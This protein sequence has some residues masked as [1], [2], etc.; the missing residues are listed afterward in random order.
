MRNDIIEY[1][2]AEVELRCRSERNTFGIGILYHIRAVA[3][4]AGRRTGKP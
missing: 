4:N 1:L 3:E 2:K